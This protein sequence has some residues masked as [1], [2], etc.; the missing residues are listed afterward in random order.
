M[1]EPSDT[2]STPSKG[3]EPDS[4]EPD[5]KASGPLSE[6]DKKG[7]MYMDQASKKVKSASSFLG[8]LLGYVLRNVPSHQHTVAAGTFILLPP[9]PTHTLSCVCCSGATKLED[10]ADLYVRAGNSFKVA[11]SFEGK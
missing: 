2:Q 5:V 7:W 3:A 8:G 6:Q 9:T 10:A 4:E 11:K 1:A